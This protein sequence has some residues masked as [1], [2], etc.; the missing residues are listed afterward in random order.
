ML[1]TRFAPVRN[2]SQCL[3]TKHTIDQKPQIRHQGMNDF[4]R[5]IGPGFGAT[6]Q[7]LQFQEFPRFSG[8]GIG[9]NFFTSRMVQRQKILSSIPLDRQILGQ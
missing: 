6:D 8:A 4:S 1:A 9:D 5:N 2:P 7:R 3:V